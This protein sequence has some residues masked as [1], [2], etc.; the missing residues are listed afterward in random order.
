MT[1]TVDDIKRRRE[2][3]IAVRVWYHECTGRHIRSRAHLASVTKDYQLAKA[4]A[5]VL[6][7]PGE[8]VEAE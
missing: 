7:D 2:L 3:E 5:A 1:L 4:V 6:G 8:D